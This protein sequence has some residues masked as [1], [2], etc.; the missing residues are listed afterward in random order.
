[1]I[2]KFLRFRDLQERGVIKN[3]VTLHN[4]IKTRAF[5]RA[6]KLARIR[7]RGL[8]PK[9]PHGSHRGPLTE[10]RGQNR[11]MRKARSRSAAER[12][13]AVMTKPE[14]ETAALAGAAASET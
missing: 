1:M 4:R 3:R 10:S 9:L 8:R 5:P 13:A 2:D 11:A 14:N 6:A 12:S 7:G